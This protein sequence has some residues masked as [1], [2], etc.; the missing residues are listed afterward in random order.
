M[1]D[2]KVKIA[3]IG[4]GTVGSGVAKILLET[5]DEIVRKTGLNLELAHVVDT[6]LTNPRP[7]KLPPGLLHNDLEK[8][9]ADKQVTIAVELVG[10]TDIAGEI[11]RKLL[12]A[13]KDVVTANKALLAERGEELIYKTAR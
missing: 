6:D 13:G 9:L 2:N 12:Q 3:I 1:E 11:Q 5:G 8:V 4:F 10:G 7:V